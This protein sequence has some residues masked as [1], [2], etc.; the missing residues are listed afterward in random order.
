VQELTGTLPERFVERDAFVL[1][2]HDAFYAGAAICVLGVL[3]SFLSESRRPRYRDDGE[4]S[5]API[6]SLQRAPR[7]RGH[8][9]P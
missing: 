8:R 7:E 4:W 2:I 6:H 5:S 1:A 3:A 9:D